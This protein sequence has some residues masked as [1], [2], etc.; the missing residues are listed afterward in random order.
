MPY[1]ALAPA[2]R[3]ETGRA[4]IRH[5]QNLQESELLSIAKKERA[6][7][8]VALSQQPRKSSA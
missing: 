5:A 2:Y 8:V 3:V 7:L 1:I 4:L 6:V